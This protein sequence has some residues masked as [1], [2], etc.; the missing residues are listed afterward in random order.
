MD[1]KK[2]K[3]LKQMGGRISTVQDLLGLSEQDMAV[4]QARLMA[5]AAKAR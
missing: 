2:A 3:K 5:K 1:A 4:I